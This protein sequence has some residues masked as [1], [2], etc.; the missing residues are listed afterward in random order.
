MLS[1]RSSCGTSAGL[2]THT[3]TQTQQQLA[4]QT[5]MPRWCSTPTAPYMRQLIGTCSS[6]KVCLQTQMH[7]ASWRATMQQHCSSSC[8][9]SGSNCSITCSRAS[10]TRLCP[11]AVFLLDPLL[12]GRWTPQASAPPD[13]TLR[14][15]QH[16]RQQR[17]DTGAHKGSSAAA[18]AA[19]QTSAA[20]AQ[21]YQQRRLGPQ[22]P[23]LLQRTCPSSINTSTLATTPCTFSTQS[24]LQI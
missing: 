22:Q 18:A 2:Q 9:D 5:H 13:I 11:L 10:T 8:N 4:A 24:A 19:G 12:H 20:A 3:Q 7:S 17:Q 14:H 15:S 16:G 23:P 6:S 21:A 1:C